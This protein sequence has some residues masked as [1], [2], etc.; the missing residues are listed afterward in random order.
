MLKTC[1]FR[2]FFPWIRT[3]FISDFGLLTLIS[4]GSPF[5]DPCTSAHHNNPLPL[6]LSYILGGFF[7]TAVDLYPFKATSLQRVD[8]NSTNPIV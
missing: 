6:A 4:Q 1:D 3:R 5:A 7:F 2:Y 8:R